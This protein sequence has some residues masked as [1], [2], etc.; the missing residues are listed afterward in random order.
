MWGFLF[1]LFECFTSC[2]VLLVFFIIFFWVRGKCTCTDAW[3]FWTIFCIILLFGDY[4]FSK[5]CSLK[6]RRWGRLDYA[7]RT[8]FNIKCLL[9]SSANRLKEL[10]FLQIKH[11]LL[12]F[13][14]LSIK[15][16]EHTRNKVKPKKL[17]VFFL[18][19]PLN[20]PFLSSFYFYLSF[21]HFILSLLK[22]FE[23]V[24]KLFLF[25]CI[26]NFF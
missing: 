5:T 25:S 16:I 23:P 17:A 6:T 24:E 19:E 26:I 22:S 10:Y 8:I 15:L 7:S 11:H 21:A 12:F 18:I 1:F 13:V 2:A 14:P 3:E 9:F 20:D 4:N